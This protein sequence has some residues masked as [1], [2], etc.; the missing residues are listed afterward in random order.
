VHRPENRDADNWP[1]DDHHPRDTIGDGVERFTLK[2][3][4][5]GA[6]WCQDKEPGDNPDE[7]TSKNRTPFA[8]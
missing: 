4:G 6:R 8:G 5:A 3:R 7:L 1:D 2:K